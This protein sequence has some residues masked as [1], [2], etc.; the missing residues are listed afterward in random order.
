MTWRD[1]FSAALYKGVGRTQM[2]S[3][4]GGP[5]FSKRSFFQL[6]M[7]RLPFLLCSKPRLV[8]F[9]AS[10]AQEEA[11]ERG[12]SRMAVESVGSLLELYPVE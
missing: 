7:R 2:S 11:L 6:G 10:R 9:I 5:F 4:V 12:F 3:V 1:Y 8:D